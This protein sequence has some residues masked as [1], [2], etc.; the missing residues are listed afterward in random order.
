MPDRSGRRARRAATAAA[1]VAVTMLTGATAGCRATPHG[2]ALRVSDAYVQPSNDRGAEAYITIAN[3]GAGAD[4]LTAVSTPAAD[5]VRIERSDDGRYRP[6]DGL[7]LPPHHTVRVEPPYGLRLS[8]VHPHGL[9]S[10]TDITLT[11]R[12]THH[13]TTSVVAQ[14]DTSGTVSPTM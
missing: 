12:F 7:D 1:L 11:L 4:R 6:I 5:T 8:L 9:R 3:T 2:S 13:G 14:V 10:G